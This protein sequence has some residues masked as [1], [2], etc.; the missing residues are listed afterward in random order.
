MLAIR[1]DAGY[2][3]GLSVPAVYQ[4]HNTYVHRASRNVGRIF[5][6][7]RE[8]S[9]PFRGDAQFGRF[10]SGDDIQGAALIVRIM[11]ARPSHVES[12]IKS[13]RSVTL[14]PVLAHIPRAKS[15]RLIRPH[16]LYLLG[17]A[18]AAC[19]LHRLD[20]WYAKASHVNLKFAA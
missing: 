5:T 4:A 17:R 11:S 20:D 6:G 13:L 12:K 8:D 10:R 14:L 18:M 3:R 2:Y 19:S 16:P 15:C 7:K 9:R 1:R